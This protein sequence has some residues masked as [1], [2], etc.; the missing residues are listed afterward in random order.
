[1]LLLFLVQ[2]KVLAIS[3]SVLVINQPICIKDE[4][5]INIFMNNIDQIWIKTYLL[6]CCYLLLS[7]DNLFIL[8]FSQCPLH[9]HG[10]DQ[11]TEHI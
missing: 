9:N 5:R 4:Q 7:I 10:T 3:S 11:C 1:M 6:G 2:P 8:Y